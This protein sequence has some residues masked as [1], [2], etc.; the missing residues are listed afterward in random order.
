MCDLHF[1]LIIFVEVINGFMFLTH[2]YES[3]LLRTGGKK[4]QIAK[5]SFFFF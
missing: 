3:L 5:E 2:N 1:M 4:G